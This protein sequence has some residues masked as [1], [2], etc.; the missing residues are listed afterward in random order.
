[1]CNTSVDNPRVRKVSHDRITYFKANDVAILL[2]YANY[3]KAV[4]QGIPKEYLVQGRDIGVTGNQNDMA[5]KYTTREGVASLVYNSRLPNSIDIARELGIPLSLKFKKHFH[6][7]DTLD[8]V[9]KVFRGESMLC[10]IVVGNR[11]IDLYFPEHNIALECDENDHKDRDP[12]DEEN[13]KLLIDA[14]IEPRWVRY[15]PNPDAF[16]IVKVLG[17]IYTLVRGRIH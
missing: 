17:E 12:V 15:N 16:D 11:R 2:G 10:Q 4:G 3:S 5:S 13:R 1:M 14:I 6:E 8:T 7:M 9:I